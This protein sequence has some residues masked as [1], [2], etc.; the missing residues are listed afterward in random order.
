MDSVTAKDIMS[1]P[2]VAVDLDASIEETAKTMVSRGVG[3]AL[4]SDGRE[5]KGIITKKD[6][7]I[8]VSEGK[9][10]RKVTAREIMSSPLVR[11][12]S[13]AN[14]VEVARKIAREGLR[15][16]VVFEGRQPVGVL[17]N[18][19]IVKVAPDVIDLLV[20]FAKMEGK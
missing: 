10:P 15:R 1:S 13:S 17:S 7:V 4:V 5:Y 11:V 3:S 19:D 14:V 16:L 20:E 9:N 12:E 6:I 8:L 18:R 2:I